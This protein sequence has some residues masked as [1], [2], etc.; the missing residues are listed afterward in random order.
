VCFRISSWC[1]VCV[2]VCVCIG[3]VVWHSTVAQDVGFPYMLD[4]RHP[5][6]TLFLFAESDFRWFRSDLAGDRWLLVA[7]QG[8][9]EDP[10]GAP[11]PPQEEAGAPRPA[12]EGGAPRPPSYGGWEAQSRQQPREYCNTTHYECLQH[13]VRMCTLAHRRGVG[14][15]MWLSYNCGS[16]GNPKSAKPTL[17]YSGSTLVAFSREGARQLNALIQHSKPRHIDL[18]LREMLETHTDTLGCCYVNPP[19]GSY[20]E[21][22]SGC[23]PKIGVRGSGF[24][25]SW[26]REGTWLE[27]NKD[28]YLVRFRKTKSAG[29]VWM[30][31]VRT[32]VDPVRQDFLRR[33]V[34]EMSDPQPHHPLDWFTQWP[35][36]M[37]SQD[38]VWH[39]LLVRRGWRTPAGEW[40]GPAKGR[41]KG[42]GKGKGKGKNR[43]KAYELLVAQPNTSSADSPISRLAEQLV[44][45]PENFDYNAE[46]SDRMWHTRTGQIRLYKHRLFTTGEA[47]RRKNRVV[48]VSR[49]QDSLVLL[50]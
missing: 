1:Y 49:G 8:A 11:R 10:G 48:H 17:I 26:S 16:I 38:P 29:T 19:M 20:E 22:K 2:C 43:Y 30:D 6:D 47:L 3:N 39:N 12:A 4:D 42:Q 37:D 35:P 25:E 13:I 46:R 40:L 36:Q 41:N 5:P 32:A 23:D 7:G 34:I 45:D 14:N 21:H 50:W 33:D 9:E 15:V 31:D 27:N 24:G 44:V 18:W 28:R